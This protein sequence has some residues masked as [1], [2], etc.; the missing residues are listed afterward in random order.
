GEV[1]SGT[2]GYAVGY[3]NG[4]TDGGSSENLPSPDVESDTAGDF[5]ARV[6]FQ[7]FINSSNFN[8]RGLGFGIGSTYVDVAGSSGT[9]T[10]PAYR[11]PGQQ[12]IF[13]YRANNATGTTPNSAS[14][15][16]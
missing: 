6:F 2:V 12:S 9:P 1:L 10:L 3:F 13:S 15:A 7:P 4:V 5:A 8:L 14:F 11:S 16:D